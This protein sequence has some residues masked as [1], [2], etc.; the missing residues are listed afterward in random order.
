MTAAPELTGELR[1]LVLEVE[2]DLRE[3]LS[4][5]SERLTAWTDEHNAAL[6]AARTS[7]SWESWR[8]ERITQSAVAWVLTTVFVRFCEDNRLISHVW[9]TGTGGRAQEALDA[10]LDYFR[11]FPEDSHREW[12]LQAVEHLKSLPATAGLVEE[13]SPL[14]QVQPSGRMAQKVLDFWRETGPDGKVL[15]DLADPSWSTRFLGDLYQ[16][17]SEHAKKTYALLQTPEFVE[18]F[19]LDQ[20]LTPALAERP[21]E[22]FKLIDPTCG[23]GHFLLG[24]F[25]RML[26]AWSGHAPGLDNRTRVQNALDAIHGVDLNPFAVAI[27]RFRLTVAALKADGTSTLEQAPA[28]DFHL[29][30]GDSLLHGQTQREFAFKGFD[31]DTSVSGFAYATE[32]LV[33][34]KRLLKPQQYD[35]VVG[36][37]PYIKISDKRLNAAYRRIYASCMGTY[38]LTIPFMERFFGLARRGDLNQAPGRVGKITSNAFMRRGYGL[39]LVENF[40]PTVDL[41]HIVDSEGAWIPGHNM[42]GTPTVILIG[43]NAMPNSAQ[44]RVVQTMGPRESKDFQNGSGPYWR[45][46]LGN[47]DNAGFTN[48][49]ISVKDVSRKTLLTHPWTLSG[50]GSSEL[51]TH[52]KACGKALSSMTQGEIGR[53]VRI[54]AD[55]AF[56]RPL[57]PNQQSFVRPFLKGEEVRNYTTDP[58]NVVLYPYTEGMA[59]RSELEVILWPYRTSL[60]ARSTFQG[61]MEDAG[62]EWWEF[63]QHTQSAYST[64]FSITFSNIASQNHFAVDCGGNIFSSHAP[65]IKLQDPAQLEDYAALLGPLGSSTACFWIRT[66]SQPKGGAADVLWTRT[67]EITGATVGNMPISSGTSRQLGVELHRL[68]SEYSAC[69][70]E[71][72][73]RDSGTAQPERILHLKATR[74]RILSQLIGLQ[75]EIDWQV[76]YEF[77]LVKQNLTAHPV[78]VPFLSLGHRAFEVALERKDMRTSS[79]ELWLEQTR[80]QQTRVL[81]EAWPEP[82]RK[83]VEARIQETADNPF[84]RIL[85][86]PQYKRQWDVVAWEHDLKS[87]VRRWILDVVDNREFW[88]DFHGRPTPLSIAKLADMV[89]R[90]D[91]VMKATELWLNRK[92]ADMVSVLTEL[93]FDEAVPYL[94]AQ[95]LTDSGIRRRAAWEETWRLQR[96]E[97]SDSSSGPIPVPPPYSKSDFRKASY[98]QARG[99]LDVPKERFILYPG[100]GRATDPTLLLGWAG[101]HHAEQFLAL[102]TIEDQRLDE[103]ADTETVLPLVAGMAELLPWV[104]Q[105]HQDVDPAYGTSMAA[106]CAEQLEQRRTALGVTAQHLA[107]WRPVA[108]TRGR[109]TTTKENA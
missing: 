1:K 34:L 36:N 103:G 12:T 89:G 31:A 108:T 54:G 86:D 16:D 90:R 67:F 33:V 61:T 42:D 2:D 102:A 101:W 25:Q 76:Y 88:Y 70:P 35:V 55:D 63:M 58:R 48:A 98:W 87:S 14:W 23:S 19:I 26:D 84:L 75:E 9:I 40:F 28:F 30:A 32:D 97:D 78:D 80:V 105:W 72:A 74:E 109:R 6:D 43:K 91:E 107:D 69:H 60:R 52:L 68:T 21:L 46:I 71:N 15:R 104:Q 73:L 83:L 99:K 62:R 41:S 18:E 57:T 24:A 53:A 92:D 56:I 94:A 95:R 49:W 39:R 37:P 93:M 51:I 79:E 17:L 4:D 8:D 38:N 10:E 64:A 3:R 59:T 11:R 85:E 96:L 65:V 106:F 82:Y 20:T 5:E 22:G 45:S 27:S 7:A 77:G 50:S 29:A 66:L 81:P 47:I 44:V 13:H 100:A